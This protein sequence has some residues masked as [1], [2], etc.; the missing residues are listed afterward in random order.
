MINKKRE[1]SWIYFSF[2]AEFFPT[3]R[4]GGRFRPKYLPLSVN[5][6]SVQL[7]DMVNVY[8]KELKLEEW[9]TLLS[10]PIE[11]IGKNEFLPIT[12]HISPITWSLI[13]RYDYPFL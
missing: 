9:K 1:V 8:V 5:F 4:G 12:G 6:S 2:S 7:I 10:L 3:P 13:G 11:L